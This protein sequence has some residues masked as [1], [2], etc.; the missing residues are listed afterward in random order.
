[1]RKKIKRVEKIV[2]GYKV[3]QKTMLFTIKKLVKQAE[4]KQCEKKLI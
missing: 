3:E 2:R 1:M 4:N